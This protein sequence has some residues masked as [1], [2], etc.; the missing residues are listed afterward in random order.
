M[1]QFIL[2]S[3]SE[4]EA[5]IRRI[6]KGINNAVRSY[7]INVDNIKKEQCSGQNTYNIDEKYLSD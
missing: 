3:M 7:I 6:D 4:Y 5:D 1:Q 2:Q